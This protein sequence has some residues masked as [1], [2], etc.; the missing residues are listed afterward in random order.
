MYVKHLEQDV[1]KW[2]LFLFKPCL[3]YICDFLNEKLEVI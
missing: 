2:Q 1:V 3:L